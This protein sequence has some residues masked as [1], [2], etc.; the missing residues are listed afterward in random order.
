MEKV[1]FIKTDWTFI[2][3]R[4]EVKS[5]DIQQVIKNL[6]ESGLTVTIGDLR[7]LINNGSALY[8]QAKSKAKGNSSIFSLPAAREKFIDENVEA[9]ENVINQAKKDLYRIL[10]IEGMMT[11]S[12]DAY[13]VKNGIVSISDEWVEQLKESHTIRSTPEREKA[14]ELIQNVEDAIKQLNDFV[15]DNKYFGA[16][17]LTFQDNRRCLCRLSGDGEL[18]KCDESIEFI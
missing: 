11:L 12:I 14:V 1:V 6:T 4:H 8:E 15:A 10:A 16:G 17:I 2:L 18:I 9:L 3:K 5:N 13:V 7:D